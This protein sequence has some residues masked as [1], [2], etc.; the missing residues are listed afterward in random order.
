[1]KVIYQD[2]TTIEEGIICHQVNTAGV[3]GSG[4]AKQIK[5]K[6]PTAFN[7]YKAVCD[8]APDREYLLGSG[9]LVPVTDTLKVANLFGQSQ[10]G[11]RGTF[12]DYAALQDALEGVFEEAE[13]TGEEIYVPHNMG[14]GLGGG[15][16]L[17]VE[18]FIEKLEANYEMELTVCKLGGI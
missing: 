15:N 5:A 10:Y 3:M 8:K 7:I 11:R 1:M 6:F 12:T 2:I 4:L 13:Q 16:W 9:I 17:V 18:K 14:C